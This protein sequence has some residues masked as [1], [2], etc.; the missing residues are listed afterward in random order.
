MGFLKE[1][2]SN[3]IVHFKIRQPLI[4]IFMDE[5]LDVIVIGA[6]F[7][8]LTAA[9]KLQEA[10]FNFLLLEARNRVG[11]RVHTHYLDPSCYVDLGGQWIGATQ[12]R[13][14]A[15][16]R[17]MEVSTFPTYNS[18]K[19]LISLNNKI[20]SYRGLIPKID[21]PSLINIDYFIKKLNRL[22]QTVDLEKPWCTPGASGLDSR[23]LAQFLRQNIYFSNARK[24]IKAGLETVFGCTAAEISLLFSL[25]YIKSGT[26]LDTLLNVE[27]GAQQDRLV[28]G[29]QLVA[30]RLAARFHSRIKFNQVVRQ[31]IQHHDQVVVSG[32]DSNYKAKKLIIAIPPTLAGRIDYQPILPAQRD[33]LMQRMP[34][35]TVIKTYAVYDQPFWRSKGL[36]GQVIS[37]EHHM[38][39]TVFDNS[40]PEAGQG[41]LMGFS[42]AGRAQKLMN[43]SKEHRKSKI[44]SSFVQFFGAE[45]ADPRYYID[46]VWA[47]E[48]FSRGCYTGF[49]P[50]GVCTTY[51]HTLK[52]PCGNIHW[53][54]TETSSIWN[55]Y[56]E[57]AI[58]SGE[59]AAAEVIGM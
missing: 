44:L 5:K 58:R 41:I 45:A 52:E 40:P 23:T 11:G 49:M 6:G 30:E 35:G 48:E 38:V 43:M 7:A 54:G 12:D 19:N 37:D 34:M 33:Q 28:G 22:A 36:S 24:V 18:G 25:F 21:L 4:A 55:G 26:S 17:E 8:G 1:R 2:M 42:L 31:V 56:I 51:A 14:Y 29:A 46:K 27:N 20:S 59:R 3:T 16:A 15:L 10:G 53:A 13:V 39:Q 9:K 50:P 57:G 32:N 47:A